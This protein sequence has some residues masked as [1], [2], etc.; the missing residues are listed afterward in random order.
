MT[1]T[2]ISAPKKQKSGQSRRIILKTVELT[3]VPLV[4]LTVGGLAGRKNFS[5]P[6]PTP[7]TDVVNKGEPPPLALLWDA[8]EAEAELAAGC[9]TNGT[10]IFW[11]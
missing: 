11:R 6:S 10:T 1:N 4:L 8:P 7:T 5:A 9:C 2:L 3:L